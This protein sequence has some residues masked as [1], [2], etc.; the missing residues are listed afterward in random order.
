[1]DRLLGQETDGG[2]SGA[3]QVQL[4]GVRQIQAVYRAIAAILTAGSAIKTQVY[5]AG[6][7]SLKKGSR[8]SSPKCQSVDPALTC[9]SGV[10]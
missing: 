7:K 5:H 10:V 8:Y 9:I 6:L 1:M 4:K 3:V 2:D